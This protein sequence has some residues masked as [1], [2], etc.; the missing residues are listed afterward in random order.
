MTIRRRT[1]FTPI[2][3]LAVISILGILIALLLPAIQSVRSSAANS[4]CQNKMR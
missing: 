3:I 4:S 2:E 1:G